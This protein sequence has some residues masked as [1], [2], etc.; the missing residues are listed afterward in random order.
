MEWGWDYPLA[1]CTSTS[2]LPDHRHRKDVEDSHDRSG[3][4]SDCIYKPTQERGLFKTEDGGKTWKK[5]LFANEHSGVVDLK[6][7]PNNPR[8]LYASTWRIQRTPY[9][10]SSG[11]EGSALW[12]SSD[13]GASWTEISKNK[14]FPTDTLGIIGVT[15]S[16]KNYS[17]ECFDEIVYFV[18]VIN[19]KCNTFTVVSSS[20][21]VAG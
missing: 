20:Y 19:D 18:S 5:V 1:M 8:I 21:K 4:S 2:L 15:V 9:S 10:L 14:G 12:K 16:P 6:M 13:S 11:G 7:D 3:Q 17:V